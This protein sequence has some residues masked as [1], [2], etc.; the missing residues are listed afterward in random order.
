AGRRPG[1]PGRGA[2]GNRGRGRPAGLIV[3]AG[4]PLPASAP[5]GPITSM[6]DMPDA[7]DPDGG[8][9]GDRPRFADSTRERLRATLL[10]AAIDVLREEGWRAARMAD[11]AARAGVSRQTLYQH[12]GS[13]DALAQAIMLRAT[14]QFLRQVEH[15]VAS[16]AD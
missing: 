8:R 14:E 7:V 13:R 12:F 5:A 6:V 4:A 1:S 9:A 3:P 15:A 11:V 2:G 16:H 10:D